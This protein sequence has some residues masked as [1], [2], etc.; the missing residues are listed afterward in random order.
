MARNEEGAAVAA[1]MSIFE[2]P[3]VIE[4]DGPPMAYFEIPLDY[5]AT[6]N[7][8]L[9]PESHPEATRLVQ[10]VIYMNFKVQDQH[11]VHTVMNRVTARLKELGGG[12]IW[13]RQRPD[14][15]DDEAMR[16]RLGTTPQLPQ[17]WWN[18]LFTDVDNRST[19]R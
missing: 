17:D 4:L 14:K 19:D 11:R 16:F 2:D 9:E 18:K 6:P 7:G 5:F 3:C 1:S 15:T 10:S 13:W 12:Y 8:E